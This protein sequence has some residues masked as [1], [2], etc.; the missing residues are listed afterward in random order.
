MRN[1]QKLSI[2][3]VLLFSASLFSQRSTFWDGTYKMDYGNQTMKIVSQG[4]QYYKA[5]FSGD[6]TARTAEGSVDGNALIFPLVGGRD[7]D[8]IMLSHQG[9]KINV[10]V[11]GTDIMRESCRGAS[12][13]GLYSSKN[14]SNYSSYNSYNDK[15]YSNNNSYNHHS[16]NHGQ[17]YNIRSQESGLVLDANMH[18]SDAVSVW[19]QHGGAN[20]KWTI[21][22]M[23]GD[24]VTI[25][26]VGNGKCLTASSSSK[27]GTS[28][29]MKSC[30]NSNT[31]KWYLEKL[32]SNEYIIRSNANS[33]VLDVSSGK[34]NMT[35]FERNGSSH[36]KWILEKTY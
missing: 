17:A 21:T 33:K 30:S 8:M 22:H 13:E 15:Y 31:Q 34:H 24:E 10:S 20:Q 5:Y 25:E 36:Q 28:V 3:L 35:T 26:N 9:N 32:S 18:S 11:R 12:I 27:S 16:N 19:K 14:N 7:S 29:A 6:C 2:A 4:G 23:G 1:L